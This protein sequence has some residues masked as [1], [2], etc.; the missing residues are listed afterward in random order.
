LLLAYAH[1]PQAIRHIEPLEKMLAGKSKDDLIAIIQD[2]LRH[3]P[4]LISVVELSTE[5]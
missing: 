4:G 5:T 2:M 1:N 3:Q